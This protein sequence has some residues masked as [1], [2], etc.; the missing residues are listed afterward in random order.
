MK[1]IP[2]RDL[3]TGER[4]NINSDYIVEF[5]QTYNDAG[6]KIYQIILMNDTIC[7]VTRKRWN[8]IQR[9]LME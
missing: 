6:V 3:M 2:V 7:T 5:C 9:E 4:R 1:L 8:T